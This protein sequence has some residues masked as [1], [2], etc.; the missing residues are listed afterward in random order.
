[1]FASLAQA[2]A[3][4]DKMPWFILKICTLLNDCPV[5]FSPP[6]SL[7]GLLH[8]QQVI[9]AG[10][11]SSAVNLHIKRVS[12][13]LIGNAGLHSRTDKCTYPQT[14]PTPLGIRLGCGGGVADNM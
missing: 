8:E 7:T 12:A 13:M 2:S 14:S 9:V 10:I 1:M 5:F 4:K 6:F 3:G 11:K